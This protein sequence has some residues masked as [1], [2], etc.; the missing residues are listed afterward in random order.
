MV[1]LVCVE[2]I[3][4]ATRRVGAGVASQTCQGIGLN[5]DQAEF[6]EDYSAFLEQNVRWRKVSTKSY[7]T[8]EQ[9]EYR[10][11]VSV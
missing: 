8:Y 4:P 11:N 1:S 10:L 5:K 7:S 2:C 6:T 9:S 3:N